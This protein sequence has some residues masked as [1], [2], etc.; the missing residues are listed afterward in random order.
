MSKPENSAFDSI[1]G[2][3][4]LTIP[5]PTGTIQLNGTYGIL[6]KIINKPLELESDTYT[7]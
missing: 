3:D 5:I 2:S 4:L 6:K 7:V 1:F